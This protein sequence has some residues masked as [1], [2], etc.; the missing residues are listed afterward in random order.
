MQFIIEV[1]AILLLPI[2]VFINQLS[3]GKLARKLGYTD[4][5]HINVGF[6]LITLSLNLLAIWGGIEITQRVLEARE[7]TPAPKVAPPQ[8][9]ETPVASPQ[10]DPDDSG[11]VDEGEELFLGSNGTAIASWENYGSVSSE[12]PYTHY[13]SRDISRLNIRNGPT[14][15]ADV[16]GTR[17]G[18]TCIRVIETRGDWSKVVVPTVGGPWA[19][20]AS[21]RFL[22]PI[23]P[24]QSCQ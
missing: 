13:I 18:G 11:P 14:T 9:V 12:T 1:A 10:P 22:I 20:Y 21:N 23:R 4:S 7:A 2:A 24:S 8:Q 5:K 16:V 6:G 15:A 3:G 19:Y 17:R